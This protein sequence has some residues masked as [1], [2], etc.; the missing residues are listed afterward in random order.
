MQEYLEG[1]LEGTKDT[2]SNTLLFASDEQQDESYRHVIKILQAMIVN[3]FANI[4]SM[5][6]PSDS[7]AGRGHSARVGEKQQLVCPAILMTAYACAFVLQQ[8][9]I[10]T[11]VPKSRYIIISETS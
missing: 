2:R 9:M 5:D 3:C 4:R 6:E 1:S 7:Y 8:P 11:T 10:V